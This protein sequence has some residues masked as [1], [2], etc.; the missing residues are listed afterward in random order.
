[1]GMRPS[2]GSVRQREAEYD[3]ALDLEQNPDDVEPEDAEATLGMAEAERLIVTWMQKNIHAHEEIQGSVILELLRHGKPKPSGTG[4]VADFGVKRW[5]Y[6]L[7]GPAGMAKDVVELAAE[8]AE[9]GRHF[10]TVRY[11]LRGVDPPSIGSMKFSLE[12]PQPGQLEGRLGDNAMGG[13]ADAF[14][15]QQMDHNQVLMTRL[16]QSTDRNDNFLRKCN[17][18]LATRIKELEGDRDHYLALSRDLIQM[19]WM[20]DEKLEEKKVKR[21]RNDQIMKLVMPIGIAM[22][23]QHLGPLAGMLGGGDPSAGGGAPPG[24]PGGFPGAPPGMPGGQSAGPAPQQQQAYAE[25]PAPVGPSLIEQQVTLLVDSLTAAQ[26][27]KI[28]MSGIFTSDQIMI[29][30]QLNEQVKGARTAEAAAPPSPQGYASQQPA[31]DPGVAH[32]GHFDD[33]DPEAPWTGGFSLAVR[34][35]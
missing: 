10:G 1:M 29:I 35:Q 24:M 27:Q 18:D 16:L 2:R 3:P 4:S 6:H 23:A 7:N 14:S 21:E 31:T 33:E 17:Q 20:I 25:P 5:R 19:K 12:R 13:D 11:I 26:M 32:Q 8:D 15:I 28:A 30:M 22:L 34:P 9:N